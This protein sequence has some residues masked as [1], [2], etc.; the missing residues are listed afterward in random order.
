MYYANPALLIT[1]T[2]RN[3]KTLAQ[4]YSHRALKVGASLAYQRCMYSVAWHMPSLMLGRWGLLYAPP[5]RI[6]LRDYLWPN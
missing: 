3:A 1:R 6:I 2:R 4:V 5:E